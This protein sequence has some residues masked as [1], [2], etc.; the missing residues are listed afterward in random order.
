MSHRITP[1]LKWNLAYHHRET[2]SEGNY[3]MLLCKSKMETPEA[4][5]H[6]LKQLHSQLKTC[7]K[8]D[9]TGKHPTSPKQQQSHPQTAQTTS[10][11]QPYLYQPSSQANTHKTTASQKARASV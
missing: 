6:R 8:Q 4:Q 11:L 1:T 2:P 9:S 7:S 3:Q 10:P 5:R